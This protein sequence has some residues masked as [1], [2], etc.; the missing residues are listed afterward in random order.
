MF[1][2]KPL[3]KLVGIFRG[4]V[5]PTMIL[6]TVILGV[7]FGLTPGWY[8]VH[9]VILFFVLI[10]NIGIGFFIFFAG[11]GKAISLIVA[12]A[13]YY[14]GAWV[15]EYLSGVLSFLASI[16]IIGLTDFARY[17]VAGALVL[18]PAIG[19]IFGLPLARMVTRFRNMWIRFEDRSEKLRKFQSKSWV[20]ILDRIL[21]GKS[22][23]DV[24]GVLTA[25][26]KIMRKAGVIFVLLIMILSAVGLSMLKDDKVRDYAAGAMTNIN[27]AEVNLEKVELSLTSGHISVTGMQWT[28][29]EKP[30]NNKFEVGKLSTDA[31]MY[32]LLIGRVVLDE[33]EVSNLKFDQQRESRGKVLEKKKK[34][35][36]PF[37]WKVD[38]EDIEKLESYYKKAKQVKEWL[39]KVGEW[40][41]E[42]DKSKPKKKIPQRYLEYLTAR[43]PVSPTPRILIRKVVMEGV[44][45]P[46]EQVGQSKVT[47]TNISD[48]P[49]AAG[50]PLTIEIQSNEPGNSSRLQFVGHFEKPDLGGEITGKLANVDLA[51][52][53]NDMSETNRVKF[54]GGTADVA[55]DGMISRYTIDLGLGVKVK[56][57][58][59]GFTG[60]KGLFGLNPN[61]SKKAIK[62]LTNIDTRLHL[63][64]PITE[65]RLAMDNKNLLKQFKSALVSAGEDWAVEE[66][67]KLFDKHS[68]II[69]EKVKDF[70]PKNLDDIRDDLKDP[71]KF[72]QDRSNK[73]K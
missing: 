23:K 25:K 7:W 9:T 6:V 54:T 2:P 49:Q 14:V 31:S 28:D 8:G 26:P 71:W 1:L 63:F 67:D 22:A 10:F 44:E 15:Q 51:Q 5:S 18:G 65:P 46:L 32:H 16:P 42:K 69:P 17:S 55:L 19:F 47:L 33:V 36:K 50:L 58:Q 29:P 35:E 68:D 66:F 4:S 70:I 41:P 39:E 13:L 20:R 40:M 61:V 37:E 59:A 34:E 12:P 30:D 45:I 62:V 56:D 72:F 43:A 52:L 64:G 11:V 53:Q 27:G 3:R 57:F 73:D 48:A 24:R 38:K 60:Q 21:I